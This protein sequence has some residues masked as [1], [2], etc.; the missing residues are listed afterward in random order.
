MRTRFFFIPALIAIAGCA[1]QPASET[2]EI[3]VAEPVQ[4]PTDAPAGS[5]DPSQGLLTE[6]DLLNKA[7]E[8]LTLAEQGSPA[9][10]ADYRLKAAEA[11]I[12]SGR[13][14]PALRLLESLDLEALPPLFSARREL[15]R[16]RV[17]IR[18][19]RPETAFKLLAGLDDQPGMG[20]QFHEQL[21][22]QR[23]RTNL[24]L[25]RPLEAIRALIARERY[26]TRS[27]DLIR[28][29]RQIWT[30]LNRVPSHQLSQTMQS[31]PEQ[32]LLGW[33]ELALAHT[34]H[35]H[36]S[37]RLGQ[38]IR[39][40]QSMHP[41]H[42]ANRLLQN[43]ATVLSGPSVIQP[44]QI[45]LLLPLT[46]EFGRA[47][48]AVHDGFIAA[49][50]ANGDPDKP[51][52]KVYDIGPEAELSPV[53]YRLAVQE[54]ADLLVGPLGKQAV[55]VLVAAE[56]ISVP[57]LLLGSADNTDS[58]PVN[59]FQFDLSPEQEAAQTALRAY[60]DGH[61]T[62]AVLFPE[63][64]WG[65]RVHGAFSRR[66]QELGGV[67]VESRSYVEDRTDYSVPIR[68]VLNIDASEA[69]KRVLSGLLRTKL[70]F[71]PRRRRDVDFLFLAARTAT[72]RLLKP[73]I[74]FFHAHDLPVY[75]TSHVY[76]GAPDPV[77]DAD[78]NGIVF[79][80]MPWMLVSDG[81][82][83]NLRRRIQGPWPYAQTA[84][85]RLYALGM[86][87]Y[88]IIP[89]LVRLREDPELLIEGVTA[90]L[91]MDRNG[92]VTRQL[93][94]ARFDDGRPVILDFD[95]GE[96]RNLYELGSAQIGDSSGEG[97]MG[98]KRSPG[99]SGP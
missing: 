30:L 71:Q 82:I 39:R 80:D 22:Q 13:H 96:H 62:T 66:W 74:N 19:N 29:Q 79:G 53:Y 2:R 59:V 87:T 32:E 97:P 31:V 7:S 61:R 1:S 27:G 98:R 90:R 64:S 23:A 9:E 51:R 57:T 49:H 25:D 88:A 36:D 42:S 44:R 16:A 26:L 86:D 11:L 50:G 60:L 20:P 94:W 91:G 76:A 41:G 58:L 72:A 12:R 8:F 37:F 92:R 21:W 78:L 38:E 93:S 43:R 52:I 4:T 83:G 28:N 45:A 70:Q 6:Q 14:R 68:E 47:A 35:G 73:Q 63:T 75:S 18:D 24:L 48:Q 65:E 15:L 95:L 89:S 34:E 77:N 81:F 69:R 33:I 17:A 46:S 67:V 5:S 85:D 40:W 99:L 55:T 56:S 3:P 54:G 10:S 84:L